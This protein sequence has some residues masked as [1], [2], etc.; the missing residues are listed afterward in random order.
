MSHR[1]HCQIQKQLDGLGSDVSQG[2]ARTVSAKGFCIMITCI[3]DGVEN[4]DVLWRV[5]VDIAESDLMDSDLMFCKGV[6]GV[7]V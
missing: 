2:S 6:Q 5:V 7:S 1:R 4:V 3:P